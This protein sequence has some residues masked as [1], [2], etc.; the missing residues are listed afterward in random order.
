MTEEPLPRRSFVHAFLHAESS[1][2]KILMAATVLALA[3]ANSP[4]A[5]LYAAVLQHPLPVPA[6]HLSLTLNQ[7]IGDGLMAIFFLLVGLEIKRELL[8]GELSSLKRAVLPL[9]GAV[10]GMVVPAAI[11]LALNTNHPDT[12]AGWAIPAATDIAF[13]IG[14]LTLAGSRAPSSLKTFLLALAIIDDMGAVIVIALFYTQTIHG[15]ALAVAFGLFAAL[16]LLN[17]L[18]VRRLWPYLL[19]GAGLWYAVHESGVH[20]TIAGVALAATIPLRNAQRHAH[21][22]S[23]ALILEKKL[24]PWVLFGVMPVFALANAGLSLAGLRLADFAEPVALGA[25]CGLF[26]GKQFGILFAVWVAVATRVAALPSGVSWRHM[27]A[28]SAIGGIGF[29]MALFVGGL[30]FAGPSYQD[31]VRLGVMTGSLASALGGL[32]LL[33]HAGRGARA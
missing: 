31:S 6:L 15:A 22:T 7:W 33:R 5:E 32:A 14:V 1:S 11:Y 25:A 4:W 19:V 24:H 29:T 8:I 27:H 21:A 18:N 23:P 9:C 2:G 30:A 26:F 3:L 28:V 12:M 13:A 16:C 10:G 20:A 17:R